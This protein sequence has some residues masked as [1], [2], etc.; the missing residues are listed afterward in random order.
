MAKAVGLHDAP[1]RKGGLPEF[2]KFIVRTARVIYG[3]SA[4]WKAKWAC[5][6]GAEFEAMVT[7]VVRGHTK[8]CGCE[9]TA[10]R[11]KKYPTHGHFL[12]GKPSPTYKSWQAMVARCTNPKHPA[13]ANYGGRGI[14]IHEAWLRSFANFLDDVGLRPDGKT[15]DRIE[16]SGNYEP[17]NVRWSDTRTQGRNRRNAV[18][19]SV[20]GKRVRLS[21]FYAEH[22]SHVPYKAVAS[23]VTKRG[24]PVEKA[25]TE[26]VAK[27][28]H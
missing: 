20:G 9:L 8:S 18:M 19:V 6:C 3:R 27:R 22:G 26:P 5:K 10:S 21:D 1:R 16:P 2:P 17:R 23:R 7:N 25:M 24:W 4:P 14:T 15:L 12:D 13:Y 11:T 28:S